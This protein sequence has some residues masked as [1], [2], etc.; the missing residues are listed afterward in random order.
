MQSGFVPEGSGHDHQFIHDHPPAT[1]RGADVRIHQ[2][3]W[4]GDY[5][6]EARPRYQFDHLAINLALEFK[7]SSKVRRRQ[8]TFYKSI[9]GTIN[10]T[11]FT[12]RNGGISLS[13][14]GQMTFQIGGPVDS[15]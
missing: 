10:A 2:N 8:L 4:F 11:R 14:A 7:M 15:R 6:R 13:M 1:S 12:N 5:S 3:R 9:H